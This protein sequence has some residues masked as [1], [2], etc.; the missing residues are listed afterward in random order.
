MFGEYRS[1]HA[2]NNVSEFLEG[3][4]LSAIAPLTHELPIERDVYAY[5]IVPD[6]QPALKT[7][8]TSKKPCLTLT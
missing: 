8:F 6:E 7:L 2:C 1:E 4:H 3:A 5:E